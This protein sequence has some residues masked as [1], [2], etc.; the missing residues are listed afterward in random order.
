MRNVMKTTST[1][2]VRTRGR[3]GRWVRVE[4]RPTG[5]AWEATGACMAAGTDGTAGPVRLHRGHRG[6]T[7][8]CPGLD[9][10]WW[11]SDCWIRYVTK[12][13][14]AVAS[15]SIAERAVQL[16]DAG[17]VQPREC[18]PHHTG[19]QVASTDSN[20]HG[21]GAR[22]GWGGGGERTDAVEEIAE[23]FGEFHA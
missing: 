8:I 6:A 4:R 9:H 16:G 5:A 17:Q 14:S 19:A 20:R 11:L 10:C 12:T 22:K 13:T 23:V 7:C 2:P 1:V 21:R 18:G 3:E 15:Q